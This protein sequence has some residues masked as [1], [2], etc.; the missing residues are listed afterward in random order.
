M[1]DELCNHHLFTSSALRDVDFLIALVTEHEMVM[2]FPEGIPTLESM[3]TKFWT[4][5][6]NVQ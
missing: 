6:D 5:P 2:L 1:W 4:W 3:M